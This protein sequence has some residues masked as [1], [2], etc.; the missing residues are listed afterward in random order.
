MA[1]LQGRPSAD[2]V[3]PGPRGTAECPAIATADARRGA[4]AM[5]SNQRRELML[6]RRDQHE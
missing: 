3:D 4:A 5:R 2:G 1:E 6:D